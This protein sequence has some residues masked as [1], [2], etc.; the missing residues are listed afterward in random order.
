MIG[1]PPAGATFDIPATDLVFNAKSVRGMLMGANRFKRD[2]PLLAD[3]YLQGR[4]MLDEL[5]GRR[6][7]LD[8]VGRELDQI[9]HGGVARAVVVFP[10]ATG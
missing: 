6:V 5:V 9:G 4:V 3:L 8:D 10:E 1:I 2:I 7:T